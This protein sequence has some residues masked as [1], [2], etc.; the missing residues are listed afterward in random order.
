[1]ENESHG[2]TSCP[3]FTSKLAAAKID[4]R[5]QTWRLLI[6]DKMEVFF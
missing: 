1:M 4:I 6:G 5:L 3:G 2:T